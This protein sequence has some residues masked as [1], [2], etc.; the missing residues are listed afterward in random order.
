MVVAKARST[1]GPADWAA[2]AYK[3]M[4]RGGIEAVAVE[5]IATELGATKGSFYWHFKN[6]DA[7]IDAALDEWERRLTDDVIADLERMSDPATRLRRL[8]SAALRLRPADRAAEVALLA[9]PDNRAVRRRVKRVTQ[10]RIAYIAVQLAALG[11]DEV[12]ALDRAV[13]LLHFYVGSLQ[14]ASIAPVAPD[15][16]ARR[17]QVDLVIDAL[18]AANAAP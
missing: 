6:R 8:L 4:A 2:A 15:D 17:R 16:H 3:A 9:N 1:L 18:V 10:R 13:L 11:W 7:L 12:E 14:M 5:P